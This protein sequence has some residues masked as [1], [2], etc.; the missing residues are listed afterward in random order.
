MTI[1]F[2][3]YFRNRIENLLIRASWVAV[4]RD[5]LGLI[6]IS[7]IW[8]ANPQWYFWLQRTPGTY[9]LSFVDGDI[10]LSGETR[11]YEGRFALKCYPHRDHAGY[12]GYSAEERRLLESDQFDSTRTPRFEVLNKIPDSLFMTGSISFLS[13]PE[14]SLGLL[15]FESLDTLKIL[16]IDEQHCD[17]H[18]STTL[19]RNV[20]GWAHGAPLFDCLVGLYAHFKRQT[21]VFMGA[22]RSRGFEYIMLPDNSGNF[23]ANEK[24]NRLTLSIGFGE[25]ESHAFNQIEALW[26]KRL[27]AEEEI[28]ISK[29]LPPSIDDSICNGLPEHFMINPIWWD[30]AGNE[31]PSEL[32]SICG[33]R[34][35]H[36]CHGEKKESI[37]C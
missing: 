16:K 7:Q 15:T 23:R 5:M 19:I 25:P 33:C 37:V 10:V 9:C 29:M 6:G 1:D 13:D 22:S 34:D 24:V 21:P 18:S 12:A 8:S 28:L 14:G 2:E 31:F 30:V 27:E 36:C 17:S 26:K 35:A 20:K 4:V 11:F 3:T 32:S